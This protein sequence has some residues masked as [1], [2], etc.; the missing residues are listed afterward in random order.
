MTFGLKNPHFF[1]WIP[2]LVADIAIFLV[3]PTHISPKKFFHQDFCGPSLTWRHLS[4]ENKNVFSFLPIFD[5][6][7]MSKVLLFF[8][9]LSF[10]FHSFAKLPA[11]LSASKVGSKCLY[12]RRLFQKK[13]IWFR[14]FGRNSDSANTA[15]SF[16]VCH[17]LDSY[18][19]ITIGLIFPIKVLFARV[20][21]V[22]RSRIWNHWFLHEQQNFQ[23]T[24]EMPKNAMVISILSIFKLINFQSYKLE[25]F[26]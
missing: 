26:Y 20:L 22:E 24:I 16:D 14:S 25:F 18:F 15:I 19:S 4:G 5:R 21:Y 3:F 8:T 9:D 11:W 2:S 1:A 10:Q 12:S 23:D 7:K 17:C 6:S 13:Y